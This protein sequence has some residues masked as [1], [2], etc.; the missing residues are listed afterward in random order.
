MA[1]DC[2]TRASTQCTLKA[3]KHNVSTHMLDYVEC[4]LWSV[5]RVTGA[6]LNFSFL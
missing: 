3:L 6:K 1:V 4:V 5:G 2:Y